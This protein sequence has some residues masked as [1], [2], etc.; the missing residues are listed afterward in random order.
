MT[1][2][3]GICVMRFV[4]REDWVKLIETLLEQYPFPP[5]LLFPPDRDPG[6]N[7]WALAGVDI[8]RCGS[9]DPRV[10]EARLRCTEEGW[11]FYQRAEYLALMRLLE[12]AD[13]GK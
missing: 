11:F 10:I 12:E 13:Y 8:E 9:R 3:D 2:M 1:A 5:A 7:E 4:E 6:Q